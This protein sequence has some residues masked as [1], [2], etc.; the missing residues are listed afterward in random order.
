MASETEESVWEYCQLLMLGGKF[1]P[2]EEGKVLAYDVGIWYLGADG[3]YYELSRA[4]SDSARRYPYDVWGYV[5]GLL[6]RAG[7]E[8]VNAQ[9]GLGIRTD[10]DMFRQANTKGGEL[11][12]LNAI[13]YFKRRH[14]EGRAIDEP[15]VRLP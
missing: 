2:T 12:H 9:H 11:D 10:W 6:G 7:W 1:V 4:D 13:A 5:F 8:L 3:G 14:I 15:P